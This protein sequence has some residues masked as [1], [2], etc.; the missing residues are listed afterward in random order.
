[1]RAL[2]PMFARQI[3][4]SLVL[5][6]SASMRAA[7]PK[8]PECDAAFLSMTTPDQVRAGEVFPVTITMRNTGTKSWEGW[9]VRL[10]SVGPK[11]NTAWGADFILIAQGTVAQ[12]GS[13][14]TSDF[15]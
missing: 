7:S 2:N 3:S 14:Y 6:L 11:P 8:T 1:M 4:V 5:L 9:P 10:R 15:E 12:P 13:E